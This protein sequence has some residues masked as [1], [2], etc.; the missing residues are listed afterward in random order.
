[1]NTEPARTPASTG[2]PGDWLRRLSTGPVRGTTLLCLPFAGGTAHYFSPLATRLAQV[3]CPVDVVAAQYPGRLDRYRETPFTDLK[4]LADELHR[5]WGGGPLVIF[6]HSMGAA[7]G[8]E[9]TLRL[10]ESAPDSVLGLIASGRRAPGLVRTQ[11]ASDLSETAFVDYV[12]SLGG[13]DERLR[14]D[15]DL[16]ELV[17]PALRADYR[18]I[19]DYRVEPDARVGVP[20]FVYGGRADPQTSPEEL[21]EWQRYTDRPI[22]TRWFEG[23]HFFLADSAAEVTGALVEDLKSVL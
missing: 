20:T 7:L 15:A 11:R 19:E 16:R 2:S 9:L 23:G 13:S 17:L 8:F 10:Q 1:M 12:V 14:T 6:G 22:R 5:H 21:A 4:T 3:D 18:A